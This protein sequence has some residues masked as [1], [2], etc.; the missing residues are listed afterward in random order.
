MSLQRTQRA[1]GFT[2]V[3]LLVVIAIIAVLIALLLPAVQQAREAAR[4]TQCKNN[5]KQIALALHN[6][7]SS[8]GRFPY[9]GN[10]SW[11][12]GVDTRNSAPFGW[13][14]MILSYLEQSALYNIMEQNNQ[15]VTWDQWQYSAVFA[16]A[17]LSQH[18]Q[19]IPAF[20]CPS[21][22]GNNVL[23]NDLSVPASYFHPDG[24]REALA[25]SKSNYFGSAGP[26]EAE[27]RAYNSPLDNP[28]GL[29]YDGTNP[30]AFC[31]CYQPPLGNHSYGGSQ[32]GNPGM[33][34]M[35]PE[36]VKIADVT[37]GTSNTFMIGEVRES[38]VGSGDGAG[39]AGGWYNI[40]WASP[41]SVTTT[42]W[43]IDPPV[44]NEGADHPFSSRHVG[45]AQ[46]A[47]ADGS[48]KFIS[49]NINIRLFN[50]L[51]S[52]AGGEIVGEY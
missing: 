3:E 20:L 5:L 28:C 4:R 9:G 26:L 47:L 15:S 25:T 50:N 17:T 21:D 24:D 43:G 41:W 45:G 18:R 44:W 39:G 48:V 40:G 2:L 19:V 49:V 31:K 30:Q 7:E 36:S 33:F 12:W 11:G 22:I 13:R 52:K 32:P 8:Y 38:I 35:Y 29:C 46:F 37:D 27:S 51:G 6:Y 10:F 23:V 16:S 42:V 34:S 14:E 1:S